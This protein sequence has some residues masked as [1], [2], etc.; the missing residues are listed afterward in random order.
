MYANMVTRRGYS[1]EHSNAGTTG[2]HEGD[3]SKL[4]QKDQSEGSGDKSSLE[5]R[6]RNAD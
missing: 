6:L 4:L 5:L 1:A 2:D 3:A